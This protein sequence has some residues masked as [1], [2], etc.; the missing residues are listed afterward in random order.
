MVVTWNQTRCFVHSV[1]GIVLNGDQQARFLE[2]LTRVLNESSALLSQVPLPILAAGVVV[3]VLI[4]LIFIL[5]MRFAVRTRA[6]LRGL[7]ARFRDVVD[8]DEEAQRVK[9]E[10]TDLQTE[11]S[12]LRADYKAK[13]EIFA[14]LERELAVFDERIAFAELGVYEPHFD[15]TDSETYKQK[16][17]KVRDLQKAMISEK[18]AVLSRTEWSVEGSKSKGRSMVN[19]QVRLT[20]RAFNNECEAATANVRWNNANAM[21]KRIERARE[22]IDKLNASLNIEINYKYL[23]LK[24]QELWLTHEMR[25]K[26]KVE[27]DQRAEARRLAREEERLIKDAEAAEREQARYEK[28]LDRARAEAEAVSGEKLDAFR[29][30]IEMLE[31]DLAEAQSRAQR[32]KS[33]AEQTRAGHVYVVSN[34][35]SFGEDIVKIGLTRRLDPD[36]RVRELGDA[37]VP[38]VFDTH[39]LIY[40]DD[41]PALEGAL[42]RAFDD[43][44]VNAANMRKE[45]F[46]VSLDE[47]EEAVTELAPEANFLRDREAQEYRETLALRHQQEEDKARDAET[48]FPAEL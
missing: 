10:I 36:D 34:I 19:R 37:S 31:R 45:F 22:Q 1:R 20:L 47:I 17:R 7:E 33:M 8:A 13:R 46:R 24:H 48:A 23:A 6:A 38:F 11:T 25:E 12:Q 41:A 44:R 35:G 29:E 18:T 5:I 4:L 26:I 40:S 39:A 9:S 14:R 21:E 3:L 32:A 16:I 27:K 2:Y 42:H 15:F 43:R 30:Q 28:L